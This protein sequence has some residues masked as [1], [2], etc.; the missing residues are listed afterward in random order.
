MTRRGGTVLI[1]QAGGPTTVINQSLVGVVETCL[2]H[3]KVGRV[4]GT[5]HGV[6]GILD[7]RLVDL[8]REGRA[9]LQA[10]ARTPGAALH[11]VRHKPTPEECERIVEAFRAHDVRWFFYVGG[12]DSAETALLLARA[13]REIRHD[14]ALFHVPK[15][16]DN[17][18][19]GSD[20]TP[21]YPSAARFVALAA[22]GH[23]LDQRSLPGVQIIVI[24]GRHAGWLTAA[25]A[26]CRERDDDGPHLVYVP[27]RAFTHEGFV[28]GVERVLARLGRCLVAISEGAHLP[29]GR[30]V[31]E[32]AERD[33]HG[34][35]QL[36]GSGALGD[37]LAE[38][39]RTTLGRKLRVRSDTLGYLQR[40]FPGCVS[41]VDAREAREVG[42]LAARKALGGRVRSGS[43]AIQRLRGRRYAPRYVVLPLEQVARVQRLMEERFLAGD[44]DVTPEFAQWLRPLVG[45][46]PKAALL[47]GHAVE[48]PR[49]GP[50]SVPMTAVPPRRT[51]SARAPDALRA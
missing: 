1:G 9:R 38:Y 18:L 20:H 30:L 28:G 32:S 25:S 50:V 12:N 13:A 14:V 8:G 43:V 11:S 26:L 44:D 5:L 10:V 21:G 49:P 45:P 19:V 39:V 22:Q 34:N 24:M 27:E 37:Y 47:S 2:A 36:S 3:A 40:S 42:R 7:A 48:A 15:T 4:L 35:V 33:S 41:P 6:Q 16:V 31:V 23:D 46:L 29:D 17:D 51:L